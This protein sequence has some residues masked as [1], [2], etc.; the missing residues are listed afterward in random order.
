MKIFA[1]LCATLLLSACACAC[2]DKM[3]T[4]PSDSAMTTGAGECV[5]AKIEG[6]VCESCAQTV[7]ANLKKQIGVESVD[8]DVAKGVAHIHMMKGK[9][10]A[11][12]TIEN[13]ITRSDYVF[14]G[15]AKGC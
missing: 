11:A 5:T 15:V 2:A 6:M 7:T 3:T 10:L 8:V 13:I 4:K 1:L 9:H 14:K 12:K